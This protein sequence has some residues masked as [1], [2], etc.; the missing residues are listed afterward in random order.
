MFHIWRVQL[1]VDPVV[2]QPCLT[3]NR[4]ASFPQETEG[5]FCNMSLLG[6]TLAYSVSKMLHY[7]AYVVFVEW[8]TICSTPDLNPARPGYSKRILYP[9][10]GSVSHHRPFLHKADTHRSV[11]LP[12]AASSARP[13]ALCRV[14]LVGTTIPLQ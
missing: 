9:K 5:A 6:D 3:A 12:T 7:P 14:P 8:K 4:L 10:Q 13:S 2:K 11:G 1:N